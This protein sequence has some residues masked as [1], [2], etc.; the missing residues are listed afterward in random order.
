MNH[1]KLEEK[2]KAE[3]L[4]PNP[5]KVG[6]FIKK[7]INDNTRF[8]YPNTWVFHD[9]VVNKVLSGDYSAITP[10]C[11]EIV[12]T[13][14]CSNRCK[15]CGYKSVKKLDGS[16]KKNDFLNPQI[17]M[18]DIGFAKSLLDKLIDDGIKGIIFTGGGEPTLFSGLEKLI[19][20]ATEKKVDSVL[21]TNGNSLSINQIDEIIKAKP[22]LVRVSLNTGTEEI[23][24]KFHHPLNKQTAFQGTL[25]TI[26]EFAKGALDT[27]SMSVGVAVVINEINKYDLIETALRVKE[28][29]EKVGG[30][31]EFITYR[32]AFNYYDSK[33]LPAELLDETCKIVET[34]VK[35]VLNGTGIKVL[36]LKRRYKT[37]IIP[38]KFSSI[39]FLVFFSEYLLNLDFLIL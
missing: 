38:S 8:L 32:P 13:M 31:I 2:I 9:G 6:E 30:G 36:N 5:F 14:N 23:Y 15:M 19:A 29:N 39:V 18:Q 35:E 21:Y 12:P 34:K 4:I 24:N 26:E 10:F 1:D 20:H 11:S 25:K 33:Q 37:I 27:P 17:H 16:W 22:L 28:I 3:V 7:D